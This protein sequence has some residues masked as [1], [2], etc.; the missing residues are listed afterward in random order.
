MGIEDILVAKLAQAISA[1]V[2]KQL[3]APGTFPTVQP[4]LLSVKEAAVYLGRTEQ[5]IQH[6]VRERSLPTVRVGRRVHLHRPDLDR[7]FEANKF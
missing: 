3:P 5:A 1:A 7:C 2:L 6:L 4:A